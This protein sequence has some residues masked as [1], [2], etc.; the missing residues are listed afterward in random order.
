MSKLTLDELLKQKLNQLEVSHKPEYWTQMEEK[1][2]PTT[3]IGASGIGASLSKI[4]LLTGIV[5]SVVV[6][7]IVAYFAFNSKSTNELDTTLD[8][9]TITTSISQKTD[10][11][12]NKIEKKSITKKNV[13]INSK[14]SNSNINNAK[15]N[16]I[17]QHSANKNKHIKQ[18]INTNK[19]AANID[20]ISNS[21][22]N[23]NTVVSNKAFINNRENTNEN[24]VV[25]IA[26][27]IN[28]SSTEK[29]FKYDSKSLLKDIS[30]NNTQETKETNINNELI[31]IKPIN[32][33]A[34]KVFKKHRGILYKLGIRK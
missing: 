24:A 25:I 14:Y 2:K 30:N 33:P 11:N 5:T 13:V 21:K 26:D 18:G 1:L 20:V 15:N 23:V 19:K 8:T 29:L 3:P 32:K 7:S 12:K 10:V 16:I 27:K 6:I 9:N 28:F 31:V 4:Y 34:K 22:L 17:D